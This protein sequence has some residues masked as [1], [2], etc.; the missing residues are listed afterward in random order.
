[1]H[2]RTLLG[3]TFLF[4]LSLLG[5]LSLSCESQSGPR[6]FVAVQG[7]TPDIQTLRALL[8]L[9]GRPPKT[10]QDT[11]RDN[12]TQLEIRLEANTR[13]DLGIALTAQNQTGCTVLAGEAHITIGS[14][15]RYTVTLPLT[16]SQGCALRVVKQG[17]GSAQVGLSDGT[18]WDFPSPTPPDAACPLDNLLT[19][20]Q[21]KTFPPGSKVTVRPRIT[22]QN[23]GSY[24][25]NIV[26]CDS[27]ESDCLVEIGPDTRTVSIVVDRSGVCSTSGLC[28]EHPRPQGQTLRKVR[29]NARNDVWFVGD[30]TVLHFAGTYFA[31]P[32]R[33]QLPVAFN[34]IVTAPMNEV[35]A[36]GDS[37]TVLRL[38][39]NRWQ[40]GETLGPMRINDAWGSAVNDFWIVG[41]QGTLHH[42]DGS[43][44]QIPTVPGL[45][46]VELLS[47]QGQRDQAERWAV[48]EQGTV[49][50]FNGTTW[51]RIPF[52]STE[53]LYGV[54]PQQPGVAWVVGDRGTLGRIE[55]TQAR[56]I[57]TGVSSRLRS[58]FS[59]SAVETWIAGDAG[60]LLRTDGV[61]VA[62]VESGTREDLYSLWGAD[63]ADIWAVGGAGTLL[64]YNGAFWVLASAARTDRTLLAAA[65]AP[66]AIPDAQAV[67]YAAGEAGTLLRFSGSDWLREPAVALATTRTLRA[68]SAPTAN[69]VWLA[70][71]GGT[72]LT[73]NSAQPAG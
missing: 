8:T 22:E 41:G 1:M 4:L 60:V 21:T 23:R 16:F 58:V 12:L 33:V 29:G 50:F 70:G 64:R 15:P 65:A 13:G 43:G 53:T 62:G 9:D 49:L 34:G 27:L 37:G 38:L 31:A 20:E 2:A 72:I 73:A 71:D 54:W 24:I 28:W 19:S 44:W 66:S 45:G 39:Q 25:G 59:A 30:G 32:R 17:D 55:G 40:C 52:P 63:S 36:V 42:F 5:F 46:N 47:I 56:L 69:E 48:G 68:I 18:L 7:L 67:A 57:P 14:E 6:V 61:T 51:T 35:V 10:P 11:F 3:W 26:G